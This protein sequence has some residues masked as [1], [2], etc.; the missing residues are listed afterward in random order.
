MA[1]ALSSMVSAVSAIVSAVSAM[2]ALSA[3][4]SALSAAMSALSGP[5]RA[6]GDG[7]RKNDRKERF[8]G[9]KVSLP[10]ARVRL[11]I[12][13]AMQLKNSMSFA[14]IDYLGVLR[15]IHP[16]RGRVSGIFPPATENLAAT[17]NHLSFST[18]MPDA[19]PTPTGFAEIA[20]DFFPIFHAG[21]R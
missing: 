4:M 6:N 15:I 7:D 12:F 10:P 17:L 21:S 3:A 8:H 11:P 19:A 2:S 14:F 9:T 20:S 5:N 16:I 18:F 13:A 1:S